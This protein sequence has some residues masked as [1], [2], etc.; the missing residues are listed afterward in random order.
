MFFVRSSL[1]A[2]LPKAASYPANG[3]AAGDDWATIVSKRSLAKFNR[4]GRLILIE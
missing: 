2:S 1:K 3:K 4:R